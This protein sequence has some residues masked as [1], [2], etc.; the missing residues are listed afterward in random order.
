V[1]YPILSLARRGLSLRGYIELLEEVIIRTVAHYGICAHRL[2]GA[3][4][5]WIDGSAQ[6]ATLRKIAA[7]GV[8]ASRYVTMHGIA[9]NVSTDLSYFNHINPCGFVDKGVTSI[10]REIGRKVDIAQ[11]KE[12]FVRHFRALFDI[13]Q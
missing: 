8:K 1:A 5:V 10:E 6:S 2:E 13:E 12:H 7:I 11:V 3:T 9:L 4:G